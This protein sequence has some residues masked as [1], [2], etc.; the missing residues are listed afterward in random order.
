MNFI[1]K[2]IVVFIGCGTIGVLTFVA[3]QQPDMAGLLIPAN[4]VI[5]GVVAYLTGFKPTTA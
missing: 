3:T 4:V 5:G 1:T 2:C